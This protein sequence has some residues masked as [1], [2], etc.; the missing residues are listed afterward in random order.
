MAYYLC[1]LS[2]PRPSFAADMTDDERQLMGTH[3]AY[4]MD[5]LEQGRVVVFGLVG[6]PSGPWGV[7][8]VRVDDESAARALTDDDPVIRQGEGFSYDVFPM[9]NA[10]AASPA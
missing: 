7:T 4:W 5:L 2:P 8:V 9:P 3:G 6:D 10:V 1:R